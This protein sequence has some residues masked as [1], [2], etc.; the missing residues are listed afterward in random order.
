M[1]EGKAMHKYTVVFILRYRKIA[2]LYVTNRK[3]K[4]LQVLQ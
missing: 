3:V 4:N 2:S 1:E